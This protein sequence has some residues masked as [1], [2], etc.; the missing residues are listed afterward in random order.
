MK[1]SCFLRA[2]TCYDARHHLHGR[3]FNTLQ[4][5]TRALRPIE[6]S[7]NVSNFEQT[8]S[9]ATPPPPPPLLDRGK[10]QKLDLFLRSAMSGRARPHATMTLV[11]C[12]RVQC[13]HVKITRGAQLACSPGGPAGQRKTHND[14]RCDLFL[15][16]SSGSMKSKRRE[17]SRA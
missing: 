13:T 14:T 4:C 2:L 15:L 3:M 17:A 16:T 7:Q 1:Q 11:R 8:S 5:A 6:L 9:R 12:D 10:K